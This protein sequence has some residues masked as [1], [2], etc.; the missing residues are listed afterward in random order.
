[1]GSYKA[2]VSRE[3]NR[4]HSDK[5]L[6]IWQPRFHDRIIRNEREL[7]AIREYI[8]NNPQH[9]AADQEWS[10]GLGEIYNKM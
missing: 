8:R 4:T 1:M 2:A 5:Q 10:A 7:Y 6:S 3:I 9:W